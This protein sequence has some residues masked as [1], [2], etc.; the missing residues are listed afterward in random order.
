[1]K[2]GIFGGSFDPIH[3]G[4][5]K[6]AAAAYS[7]FALDKVI[8]S[9]LNSTWEKK[10]NPKACQ[11][12]RKLQM[13]KTRCCDS[14]RFGLGATPRYTPVFQSRVPGRTWHCMV[15]SYP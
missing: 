15:P 13:F 4:H 11:H 7:Q 10:A 14:I 8:F 9:P 6:I 5:I 3:L 2:L 12:V 1:M